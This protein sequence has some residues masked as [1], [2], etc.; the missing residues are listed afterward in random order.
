MMSAS[1]AKKTA[2]APLPPE[3]NMKTLESAPWPRACVQVYTGDGKGKT[4]AAFGLAL[5]A[6][7]RGL[8]VYV[9]QFMKGQDYG[10]LFSAKML[11]GLVDVEQFGSPDCIRL[12]NEPDQKDVA[13]ARNG[14]ERSKDALLSGNYRIVVLDEVIMAVYFKLIDEKD[15]LALLDLRPD[16][17]EVVCTGRR[18]PQSL[19]DR[20]DLV[21]EMREIKHPYNEAKLT[22]RDGIE[23]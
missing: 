14:L 13:L 4:T 16:D 2:H 3:E 17:V 18:A 22:A 6:A 19:L 23:R 7:G 15:L 21:T 5:R 12:K 20:A 8:R 1:A 10:E 11:G 9:G